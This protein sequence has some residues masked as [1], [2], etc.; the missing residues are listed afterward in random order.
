MNLVRNVII[1]AFGVGLR[2]PFV[3]RC[4]WPGTTTLG[5]GATG[6]LSRFT[7]E[8]DCRDARISS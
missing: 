6:G 3:L 5:E 2:K 4:C 8:L 1:L 7:P